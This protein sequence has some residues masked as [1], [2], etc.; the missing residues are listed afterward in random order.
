MVYPLRDFFLATFFLAA[1]LVDAFFFV[2]LF[3]VIV[4]FA[5]FLVLDFF[6]ALDFFF[7]DFFAGS[8]AE[9]VRE[10]LLFVDVPRKA[11]SQPSEYFP[12]EPILKIDM[13][14]LKPLQ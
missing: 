13:M 8:R 1:S 10:V 12:V 9:A 7:V 11:T 5:D 2:D 4:F 14:V 6:F 3:L